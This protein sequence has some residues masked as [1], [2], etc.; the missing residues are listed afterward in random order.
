[1]KKCHFS[2]S[3]P[4]PTTVSPTVPGSLLLLHLKDSDT[5]AIC[6]LCPFYLYTVTFSITSGHSGFCRMYSSATS[7]VCM[8]NSGNRWSPS[9]K[10]FLRL[11]T[12]LCPN[13]IA[14]LKRRKKKKPSMI[15]STTLPWQLHWTNA[16]SQRFLVQPGAGHRDWRFLFYSQIGCGGK[17]GFLRFGRMK[18]YNIWSP[19]RRLVFASFWIRYFV[20]WSTSVIVSMPGV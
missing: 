6:Q 12:T 18:T 1:M 9:L 5:T 16:M 14:E 2:K 13:A 10:I 11:L 19:T 17:N 8:L 7:R 20:L 15:W 3:V 4:L